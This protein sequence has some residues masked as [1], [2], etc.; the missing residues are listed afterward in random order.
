MLGVSSTTIFKWLNN[1]TYVRDK[2]KVKRRNRE[3][4]KTD[5]EFRERIKNTN[6]VNSAKRFE[7]D[8]HE[9]ITY[10]VGSSEVPDRVLIGRTKNLR[11]RFS[12]LASKSFVPLEILGVCGVE[13]KTVH[14]LF[15]DNRLL[16]RCEMFK[17][18][19]RL[20]RFIRDNCAKN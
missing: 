9:P 17:L 13:E 7:R 18:D 4:Y 15:T 5:T 11:V 1:L 12:K 3:R 16:P 20:K 6:R 2:E 19:A 14:D 10:F 8:T